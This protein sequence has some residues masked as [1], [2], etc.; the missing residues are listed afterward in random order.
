MDKKLRIKSSRFIACLAFAAGLCASASAPAQTIKIGM[1]ATYSGGGTPYGEQ[2][3]RG[4][5]LYMKLNADKLPPGVKVEI[6]VRD[7]GGPFPDKA[8]ALAQELIVR[9]KIQILTGI[10]W[11]PNAL[12]IAPLA[13]EAK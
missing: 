2:L 7:D 5:R 11:S 6:V 12:A 13:T 10:V 4:M 9:D 3:E 8:K 1:L